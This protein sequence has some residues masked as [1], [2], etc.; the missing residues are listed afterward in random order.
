M[1]I[2]KNTLKRK[3][4]NIMLCRRNIMYNIIIILCTIQNRSNIHRR[5]T[6][7]NKPFGNFYINSPS[8]PF[9]HPCFFLVLKHTKKNC[10][11]LELYIQY[12]LLILSIFYL[13]S[14]SKI[15]HITKNI[16]FLPLFFTNNVV[17]STHTTQYH[18]R[19]MRIILIFYISS[20]EL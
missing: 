1:Q 3:K 8:P 11:V 5:R 16:V 4:Q 18:I 19:M 12:Y 14:V 15:I 6:H 9:I 17:I 2:L 7:A 20:C 13:L 10:Q